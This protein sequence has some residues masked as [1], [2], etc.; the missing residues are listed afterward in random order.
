MITVANKRKITDEQRVMCEKMSKIAGR[1]SY[2]KPKSDDRREY[3]TL[4][5]DYLN[6]HRPH[7]DAEAQARCDRSIGYMIEKRLAL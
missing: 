1:M 2:L 5:V 3:L 7:M 4:Y 6:S